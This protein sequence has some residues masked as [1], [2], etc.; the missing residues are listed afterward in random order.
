MGMHFSSFSC[1]PFYEFQGFFLVIFS[2]IRQPEYK[3]NNRCETMLQAFLGTYD[4]IIHIMTSVYRIKYSLASRLP[5]NGKSG[6]C[7]VIRKQFQNPVSNEFR[8]HL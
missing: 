4:D 8:P 7:T 1:E 5:S 2:L 6:V 3:I